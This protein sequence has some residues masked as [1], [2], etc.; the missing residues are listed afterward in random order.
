M[1][2]QRHLKWC[3]GLLLAG[4]TAAAAQST[5]P[6]AA[7]SS[8]RGPQSGETVTVAG[9]LQTE[10]DA[11]GRRGLAIGEDELVLTELRGA[12]PGAAGSPGD[13]AE[14]PGGLESAARRAE[15]MYVLSGERED[16]LQPLVGKRVEITGRITQQASQYRTMPDTPDP[17]GADQPEG[18]TGE[19]ADTD[20]QSQAGATNTGSTRGMEPGIAGARGPDDRAG[21]EAARR[22]DAMPHLEIASFRE[23]EG[24]CDG[25]AR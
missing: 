8:P 16:D 4:A 17:A 10:V 13:R 23:I 21:I 1:R 18:T 12:A 24:S 22:A 7:T 9:C 2:S 20:D 15:G 11:L 5:E 25:S 6:S 19:A 14:G 3:L